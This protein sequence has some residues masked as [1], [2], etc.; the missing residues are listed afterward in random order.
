M[1]PGPSDKH[2]SW[3]ESPQAFTRLSSAVFSITAN[4]WQQVG[5]RFAR[6]DE[7]RVATGVAHTDIGAI[8]FELW[9]EG[10]VTTLV[11]STGSNSFRLRGWAVLVALAAG[12][13]EDLPER[14]L[15]YDIGQGSVSEWLEPAESHRSRWPAG[16]VQQLMA[17][18]NAQAVDFAL[19]RISGI[20]P[21]V[22]RVLRALP[23]VEMTA[24]EALCWWTAA[25]GWLGNR[26][27]LDVIANDPD[28]VE[29][30]ARELA[31]PSPL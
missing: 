19:D 31:L 24:S 26:R 5:A 27:P 30:A 4:A 2:V 22:S 3:D 17:R 6:D 1:D 11:V 21:T 23:L 18:R 8:P 29:H 9:D 14:T 12:C 7:L 28:A 20:S 13:F 10:D 25:N 16:A 15:Q